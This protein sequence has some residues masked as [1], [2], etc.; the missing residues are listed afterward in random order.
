MIFMR[1]LEVHVQS[2][3]HVEEVFRDGATESGSE[4]FSEEFLAFKE[5]SL[6]FALHLLVFTN[7]DVEIGGTGFTEERVNTLQKSV[8][9]VASLAV[10]LFSN[11]APGS[12]VTKVH[13]LQEF[14]EGSTVLLGDSHVKNGVNVVQ[15]SIRTI[16][17]CAEAVKVALDNSLHKENRHVSLG[18]L[19]FT[20]SR[21]VGSRDSR[22]VV[23]NRGV[24]VIRLVHAGSSNQSVGVTDAAVSSR[25]VLFILRG[26]HLVGIVFSLM[27]GVVHGH[28]GGKVSNLMVECFL[29][30]FIVHEVEGVAVMFRGE[31]TTVV[32][33]VCVIMRHGV[34][35]SSFLRHKVAFFSGRL[36]KAAHLMSIGIHELRGGVIKLALGVEVVIVNVFEFHLSAFEL[37][38]SFMLCV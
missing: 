22:S 17:A 25:D 12:L 3:V 30:V 20:L 19:V 38:L 21:G 5:D 31:E 34:V 11:D 6:G 9:E 10:E 2:Q 37:C 26:R 28:S 18:I 16:V 7:P 33:A 13:G 4:G 32:E 29:M 27:A 8:N 35:L 14:L 23:L 15:S 1:S 24:H 36:E